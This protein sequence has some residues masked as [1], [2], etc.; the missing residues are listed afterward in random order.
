LAE[1]KVSF[2]VIFAASGSY[3]RPWEPRPAAAINKIVR[4][5]GQCRAIFATGASQFE[6]ID[7]LVK[8][9]VPWDR[10]ECFH[11]DEYFGITDQH[12][13][14]F[15]NYLKNRL[16]SKMSPQPKAVNLLDPNAMPAYETALARAPIDICC[17]GIG[18][19]GHIA[20][21]DPPVCDFNDPVLVKKVELDE[22][23]RKQQLGEGWFPSME[24]VPTHAATLTVPAIMRCTEISCVVPD[25]R[26][27]RACLALPASSTAASRPRASSAAQQPASPPPT[28]TSLARAQAE[29][30]RGTLNDPISHACPATILRNHGKCTLWIDTNS[31]SKI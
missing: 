26:K 3:D 16:F 27:V 14:S 29:A 25:A 12:P 23:C 15:R 5:N 4:K 18:E 1:A 7:A 10:V 2:G 13:A 21:N 31:A 24:E 17:I 11:L 22:A 30:V 8:L 9:S 6:F 19:N 20:F 28:L